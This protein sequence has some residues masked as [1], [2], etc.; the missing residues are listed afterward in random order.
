MQEQPLASLTCLV[1]S[2]SL[3]P[4]NRQASGGL[5]KD[6]A[7]FYGAETEEAQEEVIQPRPTPQ[8]SDPAASPGWLL[9]HPP[10]SVMSQIREQ[11]HPQE[12]ALCLL[13]TPRP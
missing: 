9:S 11:A 8:D 10:E 3:S 12:A 2:A 4:T 6:E 5:A 1:P 13:P 7:V